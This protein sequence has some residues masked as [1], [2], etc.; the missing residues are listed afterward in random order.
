MNFSSLL[1]NFCSRFIVFLYDRS[2]EGYIAE[3]LEH[4]RCRMARVI[5]EDLLANAFKIVEEA[6]ALGETKKTSKLDVDGAQD[7]K[8]LASDAVPVVVKSFSFV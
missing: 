3:K 2:I 4:Y 1:K 8:I 6:A 7:K 5:V